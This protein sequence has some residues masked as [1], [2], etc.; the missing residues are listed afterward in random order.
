MVRV[1]IDDVF[2]IREQTHKKI[3][4]IK[5]FEGIR[6]GSNVKFALEE[7]TIDVIIQENVIA[8]IKYGVLYDLISDV[9]SNENYEYKC[10]VSDINIEDNC[11]EIDFEIFK[12][13]DLETDPFVNRVD[14]PLIKT[15]KK[16]N[17]VS[18]Q[19]SY[20][21]TYNMEKMK[22]FEKDGSI[23]IYNGK[24][25]VLGEVGLKGM[26]FFAEHKK[27]IIFCRFVSKKRS[28]S[29]NYFGI[30]RLYETMR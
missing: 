30:I 14:F 1:D 27:T 12:I 21:R 13:I 18:R 3:V 25:Q 26:D 11:L 4:N 17:G 9:I 6:K 2:F 10:I 29:G 19:D 8:E 20:Y 7:N 15:T 23:Y 22:Y 16:D 24:M 28:E 5:N